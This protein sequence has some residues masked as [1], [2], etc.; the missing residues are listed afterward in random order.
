MLGNIRVVF[1]YPSL[2]VGGVELLFYR[3]AKKLINKGVKV[4]VVD[5]KNGFLIQELKNDKYV[6]DELIYEKSKVKL[7]HEDILLCPLSLITFF[8]KYVSPCQ[9]TKICFWDLH[10]FNLIENTIFS[11]FYKRNPDL[12]LKRVLRIFDFFR[13]EHLKKICTNASHANSL[14]FMCGS[15][16]NYNNNFFKF[17]FDPDFLPIT[18]PFFESENKRLFKKVRVDAEGL[19]IGWLGRLD[20]DKI[21]MLNNLLR[22]VDDYAKYSSKKIVFFVIGDGDSSSNVMEPCNFRIVF[23]GKVDDKDIDRICLE[24]IDFGFAVGTSAFEFAARGVPTAVLDGRYMRN[25]GN[26]G[27]YL[28]VNSLM[29]YDVSLDHNIY[30]KKLYSFAEIIER[31]DE[32]Y[33]YASNVSRDHVYENHS[34]NVQ[35]LNFVERLYNISY[36][37]RSFKYDSKGF[38]GFM[39]VMTYGLKKFVMKIR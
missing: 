14:F 34:T 25:L 22:D 19:N 37:Y 2:K 7:G 17:S 6:F 33:D 11:L 16:F 20:N 35:F 5:Y 1:L 8:E 27:I 21:N 9:S 36:D 24:N 31:L 28:P 29:N 23:L 26:N 32:D 13:V 39:S 10:P 38:I 18:I 12:F 15:N 30:E 4:A 3:L